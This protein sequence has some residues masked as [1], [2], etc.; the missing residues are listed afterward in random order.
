MSAWLAALLLAVLAAAPARAQE[1]AVDVRW[2]GVAGFSIRAGETTLLHDPYLS[3]PSLW[4]SATSWYQP[5]AAVLEPLLGPESPVPELASARAILIGHSHFDH[6]G[7]APWL[8]LRSGGDVIGSR[9]TTLIA[10][11][12]GL[13][14]E[15]AVQAE[16]GT[17]LREGPFT[18]RVIESRH[19]RVMFGRVPLEGTL[20]AVPEA[21]L[22]A[23]A[24]PLGD[25]RFYLVRHEPSGIQVLLASSAAAYPPALEALRKEGL[26]PVDLLL[27]ASQGWDADYVRALIATFRPRVVVPHHYESF[28]E[29][30]DSPDAVTPSDPEDLAAFE[31]ALR[32]AARSEGV[33]AE[34]R[35][36]GLFESIHLT[37]AAAPAATGG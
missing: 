7:D 28:F 24:F 13:P 26:P 19:A 2:L 9:T 12:Y 11:A 30:L 8:A 14:A 17:A 20:D 29:P 10:Q 5:D 35:R 4:R 37:G 31:Q 15:R 32:D 6:L 1:G 27:A 34:V 21:P 3:R 23:L 25:A 36:L 33:D 18:V 22:H 16:P